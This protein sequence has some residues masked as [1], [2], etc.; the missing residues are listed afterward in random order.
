MIEV[1]FIKILLIALS[2]ITIGILPLVA[3]FNLWIWN[4]IIVGNVLSCAVPIKSYWIMLG[5]TACGFGITGV[6][7]PMSRLFK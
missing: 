5:I 3:L 1:I 7:A 6:I 4:H 2:V